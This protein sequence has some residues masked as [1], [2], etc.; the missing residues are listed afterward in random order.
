[1][2]IDLIENAIAICTD[3]VVAELGDYQRSVTREPESFGRIIDPEAQVFFPCR[4]CFSTWRAYYDHFFGRA[5]QLSARYR[6]CQ[7]SERDRKDSTLGHASH[8][9][10]N[11]VG[12]IRCPSTC[13]SE[14]HI[15]TNWG[16][17]PDKVGIGTVT[18]DRRTALHRGAFL[19]K[20]KCA[21]VTLNWVVRSLPHVLRHLRQW[22]LGLR[23]AWAAGSSLPKLVLD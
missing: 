14:N 9:S 18:P 20:A 19:P 1:M 4:R 7:S 12:G 16:C 13:P 10:V 21:Q 2:A 22:R 23:A 8:K 15:R 6:L 3:P 17:D 11:P 5:T